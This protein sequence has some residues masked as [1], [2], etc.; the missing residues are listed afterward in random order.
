MASTATFRSSHRDALRHRQV[1]HRR[2]TVAAV[3]SIVV[4]AVVGGLVTA[5]AIESGWYASLPLPSWT[6][7][8]WVFGPAW[9]TLYAMQALAVALVI[10][11]DGDPLR[12]P[13]LVFFGVQITANLLWSVLFFGL[14]SPPAALVC[15][16]VLALTLA[17][18]TV[19][20]ARM[21]RGAGLLMAV[22]LVWVGFA[23]ALNVA[24]VLDA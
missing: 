13:A 24:V 19:F 3:A 17:C 16:V 20:F 23:I 15:N 1:W 18:A 12:P 14:R 4:A 5:P 9:T 21:H 6:P 22:N 10:R 11:R 8:S 2:E 7:A